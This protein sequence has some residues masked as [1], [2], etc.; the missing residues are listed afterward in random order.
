MCIA[1]HRTTTHT[2]YA[3]AV[4]QFHTSRLKLKRTSDLII[5]VEFVFELMNVRARR[6]VFGAWVYIL[7]CCLYVYFQIPSFPPFV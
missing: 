6:P 1:N 4:S 7:F 3:S 2:D 5:V